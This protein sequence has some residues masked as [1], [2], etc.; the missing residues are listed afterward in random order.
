MLTLNFQLIVIL[1]EEGKDHYHGHCPFGFNGAEEFKY[2]KD[3][4][5]TDS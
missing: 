4:R 5:I 2:N 3:S 1:Q